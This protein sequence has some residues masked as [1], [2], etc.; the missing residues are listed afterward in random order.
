MAQ[1]LALARVI[2]DTGHHY[3]PGNKEAGSQ[4][5]AAVEPEIIRLVTSED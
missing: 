3:I 1:Q 5:M 2:Q 4:A